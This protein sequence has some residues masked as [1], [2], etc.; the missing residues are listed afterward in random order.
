MIGPS[1]FA[2]TDVSVFAASLAE[3]TLGGALNRVLVFAMPSGGAPSGG[4]APGGGASRSLSLR[5]VPDVEAARKAR[6]ALERLED[7][8]EQGVL[9]DMHL[10]VTELVTNSVRH[11]DADAREP[12]HVEVAVGGDHVFVSVEDGGSGFKPTPR[13]RHAPPDSGWGLHLVERLSSRWGV[14]SDGR[15]RVWLELERAGAQG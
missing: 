5:L 15:T 8:L 6:E 4:G 10:L 12:V 13:T 1:V 7:Q 9:R 11:A 2:G 14:S 3:T